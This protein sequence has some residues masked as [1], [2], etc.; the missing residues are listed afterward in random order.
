MKREMARHESLDK[1]GT[2]SLPAVSA[3]ESVEAQAPGKT[4]GASN[5]TGDGTPLGA[6]LRVSL[7]ET[8]WDQD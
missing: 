6:V 2:L 8:A 3:V 7:G 4:R 5:G 1:L